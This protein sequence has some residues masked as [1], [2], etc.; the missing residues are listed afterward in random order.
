VN[1]I[2]ILLVGDTLRAEFRRAR[3]VLEALGHVRHA[4]SA[5]EAAAELASGPWTPDV[6][7]VAQAY[8]GQFSPAALDGLRRR[9]PLA[10]VVALLGS[11]CE[12]EMRSGR[13]SPGVIRLYWHQ[14]PA[15]CQR[16][17]RRILEGRDSTW[18]L[19]ATATEEERLLAAAK[20]PW[21]RRQ[22]LVAIATRRS[23]MEAVLAAICRA[24]GYATVWL[25]E[26]QAARV[27]G[28]A[29][30]IFDAADG[31]QEELDQVRRL[32]AAL[33][34]APLVVL[35]DFPRID[36]VARLHSAGAAALLAKPLHV[37]DLV[38]ALECEAAGGP[39]SPIPILTPAAKPAVGPS[40]AARSSR[41]S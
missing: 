32:S 31:G 20:T 3:E 39:Q 17:L 6:I 22:G 1:E 12:G 26:P 4:P 10:R 9:A 27:E 2:S 30:A 33:A 41:P 24:C 21:P 7:V 13:P 37:D 34:P 11:W 25:R 19:P 5:D 15:R 29:A 23:E 40:E 18:D 38:W 35:M 16:Q 28:A 36:D 8:P 14:G